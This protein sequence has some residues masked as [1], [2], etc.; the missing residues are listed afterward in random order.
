MLVLSDAHIGRTIDAVEMEGM[1][2]YDFSTFADR[3]WKVIDKAITITRIQRYAIPIHNIH[4]LV[5]GDMFND[6]Q[7][8]ENQQSNEMPELRGVL[9]GAN[10]LAQ[11][12]SILTAHFDKV[13][14][15]CVV[16][17]EPRTTM[18]KQMRGGIERNLDWLGYQAMSLY[19]KPHIDEGLV[20]MNIPKAYRYLAEIM[21]HRVLIEHGDDVFKGTGGYGGVGWYSLFKGFISETMHRMEDGGIDCLIIGHKHPERLVWDNTRVN[22]SICGG[23]EYAR[24]ALKK[25]SI[26]TQMFFGVSAKRI[27]T[28][29]YSIHLDRTD[30][31]SFVYDPDFLV[32]AVSA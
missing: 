13:T 3:Y 20:E 32:A 14:V 18:R 8:P 6:Y 19:L 30:G 17:N 10:V 15:S 2:A 31:N 26:P 4:V 16:G 28:W 23:D 27:P 7:R 29:E 24:T 12:L 9:L 1:N 25:Y 11:G 22:G 21:G 5:L